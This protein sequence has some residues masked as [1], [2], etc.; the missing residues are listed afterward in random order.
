MAL[1]Q[2]NGPVDPVAVSKRKTG[3]ATHVPCRARGAPAVGRLPLR[4]RLND[5]PPLNR[6][7]LA[8]RRVSLRPFS[9]TIPRRW[10]V[11]A[12]APDAPLSGAA[13]R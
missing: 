2:M 12:S 8:V 10:I 9:R 4:H 6:L 11:R 5:L 3:A 13:G 1:P 7:P